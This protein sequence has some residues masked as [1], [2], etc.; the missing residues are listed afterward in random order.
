MGCFSVMKASRDEINHTPIVDGQLFIETDQYDGLDLS[1]YNKIYMDNNIN[2]D[3]VRKE[4]G[5]TSWLGLSTPFKTLDT[6]S[7]TVES[8]VLKAKNKRWNQILDKP[9]ET[10]G[11]TLS[12][13]NGALTF[14]YKWNEITNKP[15]Y[16]IG[17]GLN[18]DSNGRLN[19]DV[20]SVIAERIGS[21]SDVETSFQPLQIGNLF[22]WFVD[23]VYM[24]YS[25]T[26]STT[27]DTVF[28]FTSNTINADS[29]IEVYTSIWGVNPKN[30]SVTNNNCVVTFPSHDTSVNLKCRIYILNE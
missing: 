14:A 30:I 24:E 8:N 15:F 16:T 1:K 9:F 25:Q 7:L 10:I 12:V 28:T 5:I 22:Y 20:P 3:I 17:Y 23:S 18:V 26:L 29:F 27:N 11:S 2:D 13:K 21:A 6:D 4:L 19:A